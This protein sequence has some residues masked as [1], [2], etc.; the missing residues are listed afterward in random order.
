MSVLLYFHFELVITLLQALR[1][2]KI[3][4]SFSLF[5]IADIIKKALYHCLR[6]V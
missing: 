3:S 6:Q 2:S 1:K 4:Y 5:L